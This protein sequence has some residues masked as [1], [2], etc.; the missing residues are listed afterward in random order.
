MTLKFIK[1]CQYSQTQFY[2]VAYILEST[3]KDL[4][5]SLHPPTKTPLSL[6]LSLSRSHNQINTDPHAAQALHYN[7]ADYV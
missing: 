4:N 5:L 7:T 1:S 2:Y 3:V 6:S